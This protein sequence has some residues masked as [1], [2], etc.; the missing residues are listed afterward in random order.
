MAAD[1]QRR[2]VF[3]QLDSAFNDDGSV[4]SLLAAAQNLI[5]A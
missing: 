1:D 3:G 5:G 4:P 2:L